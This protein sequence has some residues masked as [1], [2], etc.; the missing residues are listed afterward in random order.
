MK[1]LLCRPC[2]EELAKAGKKL[3]PVDARTE[4]ITCVACGRRRYGIPYEVSLW[5][6][7][8]KKEDKPT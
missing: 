7:V 4:K 8:F 5:P 6:P 3:A 2:A 1:K